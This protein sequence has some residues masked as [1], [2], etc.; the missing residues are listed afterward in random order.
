M[1]AAAAYSNNKKKSEYRISSHILFSIVTK[2]E[3]EG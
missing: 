3:K 2:E 1:R